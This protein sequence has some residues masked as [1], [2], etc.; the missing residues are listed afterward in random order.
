MVKSTLTGKTKQNSCVAFS[1]NSSVINGYYVNTLVQKE[2]DKESEMRMINTKYDIVYT[3]ETH[4][5]PT[6]ISPFAGAATGVGG[7]IRDNQAVGIGGLLVASIAGYCVGN[8]GFNKW[9]IS[10]YLFKLRNNFSY[11][12]CRLHYIKMNTRHLCFKP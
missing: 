10:Y 9:E 12:L 1:D 3:A 8:L 2:M 7:R 5:Y 6:G 11:T 4:N